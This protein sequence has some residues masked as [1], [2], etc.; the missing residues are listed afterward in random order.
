MNNEQRTTGDKKKINTLEEALDFAISREVQAYDFYMKWAALVQKPEMVKVL[1]DLAVEEQQHKIRLE[2]AKAGEVDIGEEE[3]GDLGLSDFVEDI[4]PRPDMSYNDLLVVAMKKENRSYRLY[5]DIALT[6]QKLQ[7]RDIFLKLAQ[8][9]AE[10]RLRFEIEY[11]L[12]T[13]QTRTKGQWGRLP[14]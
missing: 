11:D 14:Y 1:K 12:A 3:V 2:A 6:V 5:M 10:H 9:E 7:L 13:F 4:E 8:E